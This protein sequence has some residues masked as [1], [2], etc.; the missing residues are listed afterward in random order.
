[1][2]MDLIGKCILRIHRLLKVCL[3][4]FFVVIPFLQLVLFTH[5]LQAQM[6]EDFVRE[7]YTI[8]FIN[9]VP[10][11]DGK[12][13]DLVWKQALVIDDYYQFTPI[14]GAPPSEKTVS[15]LY[16]D[17]NN[18]YLAFRC[19]DSEPSQIRATL[20]PRNQWSSNDNAFIY[21]D[22]FDNKRDQF[23]FMINPLGVQW[24]SFE[25]I[26]F[27]A[28]KIDSMG[29][30]GEIAIPFKS[31]RF[32]NAD[33]QQWG[34]VL[35]RNIYR[36]GEI[37]NSINV[38]E[39]DDF[40]AMFPAAI[41]LKNLPRNS[42]LEFLPYGAAK[43]SEGKDFKDQDAAIGLDVKYG[44]ASN[45]ILDASIAPDFSQVESDPFFKNFSPYEYQLAENRPFFNEGNTFFALPYSLFYS[46]R[47][48][49]PR[50]MLKLTG[51][52]GPWNIGVI[53]AWDDQISGSDRLIHAERLQMDIL[54]TSK[55]GFMFSGIEDGH[56][57]NRNLAVDGQISKGMNH[58]LQFQ[59][60]LTFN[61]SVDSKNNTLFYLHH[62]ITP[63]QG[64][65]YSFNYIDIAPD[66]D[67]KTGIIGQ[68]GFRNP[69]I[70]LGYIWHIPDWGI[71]TLT[72]SSS[73]NYS[74]SYGGLDI[75]KGGGINFGCYFI[76]KV[77]IG[78][79][80]SRNMGRSQIVK[81]DNLVWN[82]KTFTGNSTS[83]SVS[84]NTGSVFDGNISYSYSTGTG[85][86]VNEFREQVPGKNQGL[87]FG[88]NVKPI[89]KLTI[90]NSTNWYRQTLNGI[91]EV[92]Y[93]IWLVRN[94]IHYQLTNHL[95]SRIVQ[96]IDISNNSQLFNILFGYEFQAGS[97][98]YVS[99]QEL[100][101]NFNRE[102]T[103][104]N[105]IIFGK[106]SYLFR[107]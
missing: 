5:S 74:R 100:R 40:Y 13:N 16:Y 84:S 36:R 91:D 83:L 101:E 95:F 25:T 12:V 46:R 62:S 31:L 71:E 78:L 64:F 58:H 6:T 96:D 90:K 39:D 79:S 2:E 97:T 14:N 47:V 94:S 51:K 72:L 104:Q 19:Y 81:D 4:I 34:F 106:M 17:K 21:L 60:A 22:T 3:K 92:L 44:I 73:A 29:W 76:K 30:T 56:I 33:E 26:W 20:T 80:F 70:S 52:E 68:R 27:S 98:F 85:I 41:G 48:E 93:N 65:S 89:S 37:L 10:L 67:P 99:Y 105:Y 18:I 7:E 9:V 103:R 1:M 69:S 35:G 77:N 32:P 11:I 86:Y 66:Y 87:G 54:E 24:N 107:L 8:P 42:N 45:L 57:Y 28:A 63:Y 15:F 59:F 61:S 53:N 43:Q 75:G 82:E 38:R 23:L 88:L 102:F 50:L 49:N 55:L